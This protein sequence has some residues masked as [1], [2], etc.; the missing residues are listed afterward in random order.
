MPIVKHLIEIAGLSSLEGLRLF[1]VLFAIL[2]MSGAGL[3]QAQTK[4]SP[5]PEYKRVGRGTQTL[6]LIP[7]MSCRWNEWE[8][9]MERNQAKYTMYAVTIPGYGGTPV[10]DLSKDTDR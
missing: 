1:A 5:I 8:E 4:Y 3:A 9:F 6:L 2:N 7:C 10:P